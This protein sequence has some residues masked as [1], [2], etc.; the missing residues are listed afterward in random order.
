MLCAKAPDRTL[1]RGG[2]KPVSL[3]RL[4]VRIFPTVHRNGDVPEVRVAIG[5]SVLFGIGILVGFVVTYDQ[6]PN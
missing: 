3:C 5:R 2:D 1:S 6:I 4:G